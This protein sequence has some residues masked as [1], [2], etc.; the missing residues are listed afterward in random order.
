MARE[1]SGRG[2]HPE[3]EEALKGSAQTAIGPVMEWRV[4][5]SPPHSDMPD[6]AWVASTLHAKLFALP[7]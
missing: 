5:E 6:S 1:G 7:F 2:D 4:S 3:A